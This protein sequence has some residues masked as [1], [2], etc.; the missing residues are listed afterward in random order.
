MI[1]ESEMRVMVREAAEQASHKTMRD[2]FKLLGV[3]IDEQDDIND[4]R[5]D[6]I[7][8]REMRKMSK[9]IWSKAV[10]VIV[11]GGAVWFMTTFGAG[12]KAKLGL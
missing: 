4:L 2:L 5:A 9:T 11:T 6:L 12:I 3:D 7:Y 8:A 10:L 1:S